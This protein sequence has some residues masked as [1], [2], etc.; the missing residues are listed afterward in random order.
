MTVE[1]ATARY[2]SEVGQRTIYFCALSCKET[3]DRDP[4]RYLTP[5]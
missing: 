5:A 2:R 3:F 1:I 4:Q